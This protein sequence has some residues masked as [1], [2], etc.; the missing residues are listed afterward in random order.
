MMIPKPNLH[1]SILLLGASLVLASVSLCAAES[2]SVGND[3][4]TR[5]LSWDGGRLYTRE[6]ANRAGQSSAEV[7]GGDEFALTVRL[8]GSATDL[9]LTTADFEVKGSESGAGNASLD[10]RLA[11]KTVALDL[12]VRYF[13]TAGEPWMRKQ[14]LLTA[15]QAMQI[16]KVEIEHLAAA[17]AHAPYHADQFTARGNAK[18]RPPLGQPLYT[19]ISGLWWGVEFPAARNEVKDGK[20]VCGYLTAVDLKPGETWSSHSAAVNM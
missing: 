17:D 7:A 8:E 13:A 2:V 11:A 16:R 6:V 14:L 18:W 20:L 5:T 15:R 12:M 9:R 3:L 19:Q 1:P 10:V 4:V